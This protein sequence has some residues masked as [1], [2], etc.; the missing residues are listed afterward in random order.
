MQPVDILR[1]E[2][3]ELAVTLE[4]DERPVAG[5]RLGDQGDR[6]EPATPRA[7]A[8]LRVGHVVLQGCRLLG[9]RILGPQAL[10]AA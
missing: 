2:G 4:S 9:L 6:I 1:D 3:V 7:L 8:D 5:V 10:G